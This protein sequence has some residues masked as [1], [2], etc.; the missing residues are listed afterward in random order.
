MNT[1][2]FVSIV[3]SIALAVSVIGAAAAGWSLS[4]SSVRE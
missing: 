1:M 4:L 2:R 3:A